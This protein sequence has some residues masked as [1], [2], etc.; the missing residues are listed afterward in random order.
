MEEER[1]CDDADVRWPSLAAAVLWV[2]VF[3][4]ALRR[5]REGLP[6]ATWG[7]GIAVLAML[8]YEARAGCCAAEAYR[9]PM[10]ATPALLL[11]IHWSTST[12]VRRAAPKAPGGIS[13]DA[14][15]FAIATIMGGAAM[16]LQPAVLSERQRSCA[17]AARRGLLSVSVGSFFAHLAT[18][19]SGQ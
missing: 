15:P 17:M 16:L 13:D 10:L 7:V 1:A 9:P 4:V 8:L 2:V 19:L 14:V 6:L 3:A 5:A 12:A 11:S 18:T